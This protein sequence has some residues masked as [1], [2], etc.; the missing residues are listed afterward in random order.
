MQSAR[1]KKIAQI[2]A[3]LARIQ[4]AFDR[5]DSIE[6]IRAELKAVEQKVEEM[7]RV[8]CEDL[9]AAP[10]SPKPP[11]PKKVRRGPPRADV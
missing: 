1:G 11:T 10:I 2:E 3:D 4:A 7:K 8:Y 9:E 5:N 6:K